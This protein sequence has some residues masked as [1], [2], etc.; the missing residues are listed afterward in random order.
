MKILSPLACVLTLAVWPMPGFACEGKLHIEI[1]HTGVYAINHAAIVAQQPGLANCKSEMLQM[2]SAG[3]Q[4]PIRVIDG[5][6]GRFDAGDS[7]EW[8]G[9]Q[10]Q[11]SE[12]WFNPFS[13]NNVY[14]L[15]AS[16]GKHARIRDALPENAQAAGASL[17]RALH[18]EQENLMIRLDQSQQEPGAEPDVWQWA[19]ITHAD[20]APFQF[21]FDLPDLDNRDGSVSLKLNF[22]GLSRAPNSIGHDTIEDHATD[23][24]I[25]GSRIEQLVWSG[26][27]EVTHE[28]RVSAKSLKARGNALTITVPKRSI[29]WD[30][31]NPLV[32]VVMFNW[33]EFRFGIGG[34]IDAG[35]LPLSVRDE[36]SKPIRLTW[37][38]QGELVLYGL[39]GVRR[40]ALR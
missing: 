5:G 10:L 26:R 27:D 32:D 13:I 20:P 29:P 28:V 17:Q 35:P 19:K 22:R 9:E 4:V 14:L 18:Y 15:G 39:D 36:D 2:A 23:V 38:A 34:D 12:S 33:A 1:E 8:V 31:R 40:P 21:T 11:G 37:G 7:I 30:E 25:N 3:V 24:V 6:D 16:I